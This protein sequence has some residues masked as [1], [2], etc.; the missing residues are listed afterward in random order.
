MEAT[1][2][3]EQRTDPALVEPQQRN[4]QSLDHHTFMHPDQD[5]GLEKPMRGFSNAA[6]PERDRTRLPSIFP[7]PNPI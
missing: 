6:G 4:E 2:W 7:E 3:P 1:A 5:G